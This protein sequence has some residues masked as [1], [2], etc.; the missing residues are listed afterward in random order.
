MRRLLLLAALALL[1]SGCCSLPFSPDAFSLVPSDATVV[2]VFKLDTVLTGDDLSQAYAAAS[3][4][5]SLS[6]RLGRLLEGTGLDPRTVQKAAFF[7]IE[8]NGSYSAFILQNPADMAAGE[9]AVRANSSWLA[10][11]YRDTTVFQR[12]GTNL[13]FVSGCVVAGDAPAVKAAIDVKAGTRGNAAQNAKIMGVLNEMDSSSEILVAS[14]ITPTVRSG[15]ASAVGPLGSDAFASLDSAGLQMKENASGVAVKALLRVDTPENAV[16]LREKAVTAISL[17]NAMA[18]AGG[19]L[20][21]FLAKIQVTSSGN[22]SY[23]SV[24]TT[25]EE[26]RAVKAELDRIG[27][28]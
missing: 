6:G 2:A 24:V 26:L 25:G 10:S 27:A 28:P 21:P 15:L 17:L 23:I 12:G 13:A 5:D 9:A 7:T 3:G 4:W 18:P 22:S 14:A 19:R 8:A 11:S 1:I 16:L 20:G